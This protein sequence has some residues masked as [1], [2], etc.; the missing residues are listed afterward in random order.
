MGTS[1]R[2]VSPPAMNPPSIA[3]ARRLGDQLGI[4]VV[5]PDGPLLPARDGSVFVLGPDAS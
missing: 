4:E 5:A 2:L 3:S 1:V